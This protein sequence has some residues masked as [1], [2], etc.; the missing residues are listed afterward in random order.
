MQDCIFCKIVAG[1]IAS[2]KVYEDNSLMAFK[3]VK[4]SAPVHILIVPKVHIS[5]LLQ[6][7]NE[8]LIK[9]QNLA[10]KLINKFGIAENYQVLTNGGNIQEIKH[11]HYHVKGGVK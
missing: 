5:D 8:I 10:R 1:K 9:I 11:L 4:P 2:Q 3:D 6:S 7:D